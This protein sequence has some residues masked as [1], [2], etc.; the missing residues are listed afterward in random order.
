MADTPDTIV[1]DAAPGENRTAVLR[2]GRLVELVYDR[3][4]EPVCDGDIFLARVARIP[5]GGEGAFLTL[6]AGLDAFLP[7]RRAKFRPVEGELIPVRVRVAQRADKRIVVARD[8]L[9][10]GTPGDGRPG[11]VH[12]PPDRWLDPIRDRDPEKIDAILVAE[13]ELRTRIADARPDLETLIKLDRDDPP[14]FERLGIEDE[15][16]RLFEPRMTLPGGGAIAIEETAA[17]TTIDVDT[18]TATGT[19]PERVASAV[20]IEAAG[21][22]ARQ[23]R[24]RRLG[25]LVFVDFVSMRAQASKKAVLAAL[26]AALGN[27]PVPTERTGFSHFGVV[28]LNRE[29]RGTPLLDQIGDRS[30]NLRPSAATCGAAI[31]RALAREVRTAP[32]LALAVS[33][34]EATARWLKDAAI[35]QAR[36]SLHA[37]IIVK[38]DVEPGRWTVYSRP[39]S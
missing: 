25:G 29:R 2:N 21:E 30:T 3:P 5:P 22:I 1:I 39:R 34:D 38:A 28:E 10:P 23:L 12:R 32:G 18:G 19:D 17:G 27:D 36:Q 37:E 24:L 35:E 26:D 7:L 8:T 15:I 33:C 9:P 20:N 6:G 11:L 14:L 13:P 16:E 31:L 4:W